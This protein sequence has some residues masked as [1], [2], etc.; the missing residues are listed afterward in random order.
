MLECSALPTRV[1]LEVVA[2]FAEHSE[3]LAR[4]A[5]MRQFRATMT[6]EI[7]ERARRRLRRSISSASSGVGDEEHHRGFASRLTV[8]AGG[9]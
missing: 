1:G 9:S 8:D 7:G 6:S 3:S 4:P 2:D 5:Q